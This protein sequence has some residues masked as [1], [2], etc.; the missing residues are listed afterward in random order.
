MGAPLSSKSIFFILQVKVFFQK[1]SLI[2]WLILPIYIYKNVCILQ[3]LYF[4]KFKFSSSRR[5]NKRKRLFADTCVYA[6][7]KRAYILFIM[8]DCYIYIYALRYWPTQRL[9]SYMLSI[10]FSIILISCLFRCLLYWL[11]ELRRKRCRW[12][13]LLCCNIYKKNKQSR[14]THNWNK[15]IVSDWSKW[16]RVWK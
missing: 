13:S 8:R 16:T 7:I 4:F 5:S 15:R 11:I 1:I 3:N 2:R 14:I 9:V 12:F 6:R 10:R